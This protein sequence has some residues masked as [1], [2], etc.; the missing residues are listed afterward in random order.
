VGHRTEDG[1]Q[2]VSLVTADEPIDKAY[3]AAWES[4]DYRLWVGRNRGGGYASVYDR[5]LRQV[6]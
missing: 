2:A 5:Q 4:L 1:S 3:M 6:K